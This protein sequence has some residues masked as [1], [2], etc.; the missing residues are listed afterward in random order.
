MNDL[1]VRIVRLEPMRVMCFNG[2]GPSPEQ[3]AWK[4]MIA[5]VK[6]KGLLEENK[7]PRFFGYNN[8]NPSPGSPNYGY[9]FWVTVDANLQ[10]EGDARVIDFRGGLY[11][12]TRCQGVDNITPTWKKLV[13]WMEQSPY[14]HAHHQWLEEHIYPVAMAPQNL[15][16][17]VMDLYLPV[18]G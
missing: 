6:E 11:A 9:D 12:V 13:A 8:P 5:W 14:Q 18:V 10:P 2:F 7:T 16:E 3:Q 17:L 15:G 4:K 1:E